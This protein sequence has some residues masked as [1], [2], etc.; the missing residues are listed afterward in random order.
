MY[1]MRNES[2]NVSNE[3]FDSYMASFISH[4]FVHIQIIVYNQIKVYV[5]EASQI[6]IS[7]RWHIFFNRKNRMYRSGTQDAV[8]ALYSA[9]TVLKTNLEANVL[10]ITAKK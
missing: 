9:G 8:L 2:V 3:S 4:F 10:F 1:E 7:N 5:P 6:Q